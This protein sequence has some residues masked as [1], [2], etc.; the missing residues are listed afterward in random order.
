MALGLRLFQTLPESTQEPKTH[1]LM[2]ATI[3]MSL[4]AILL[5]FSCQRLFV[6]GIVMSGL[7][8]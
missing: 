2:T 5:F 4:P 8:G 6:R 1:L 7:K 3:I